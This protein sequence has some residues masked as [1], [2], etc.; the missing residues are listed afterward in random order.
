MFNNQHTQWRSQN[1]VVA[2]AGPAAMVRPY[3]TPFAYGNHVS[4]L[5]REKKKKKKERN[6]GLYGHG[7][8]GLREEK[9]RRLDSNLCVDGLSERFAVAWDF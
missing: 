3:G 8:T 6:N 9:W 5:R 7:R 4:E 2:M 1:R